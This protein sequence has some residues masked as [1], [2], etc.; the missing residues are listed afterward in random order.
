MHSN[1]VLLCNY[2]VLPA[3]IVLQESG[4]TCV[5]IWSEGLM[6]NRHISLHFFETWVSFSH[7]VMSVVQK[8]E[9]ASWCQPS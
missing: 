9:S 6:V 4:I 7:L 8:V 2:L 1:C 3:F 5:I